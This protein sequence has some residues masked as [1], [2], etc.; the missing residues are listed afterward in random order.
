LRL[1]EYQP[2]GD[3]VTDCAVQLNEPINAF[4][5]QDLR[6]PVPLQE[7][8]EALMQLTSQLPD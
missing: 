6:E 2:G 1:G 5:R 3:P 4:L 7:T 8:I